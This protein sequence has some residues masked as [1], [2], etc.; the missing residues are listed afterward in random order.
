MRKEMQD[1][2]RYPPLF[3]F[4]VPSSDK[5]EGTASV[6]TERE[7]AENNFNGS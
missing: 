7:I 6:V 2:A 3:R 1:K 4:P 5:K